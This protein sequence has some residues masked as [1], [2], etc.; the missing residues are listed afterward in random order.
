M[1]MTTR[2]IKTRSRPPGDIGGGRSRRTPPVI[3]GVLALCPFF[4]QPSEADSIRKFAGA[5]LG[6]S[7]YQFDQKIDQKLVFSTVNVTAG[8]S[9]ER[10]NFLFNYAQS[11]DSAEVSEEEFTGS[12][13]RIDLDL[14]VVR[15][16]N[17]QLSVFLGYKD[18]ETQLASYSRDEDDT[19][20]R[21][22]SFEQEGFFV[23]ASVN[24]ILED[25]GRL[26]LSVAYAD[27]DST[28]VFV[29]DGDGADPGEEPEFDDI[30]GT[31]NGQ[32][33]GYSYNLAWTLPL[34][35]NWL[36]RARL[37]L[38]RYKQDIVFEGT[39]FN[40]IDEGSTTIL[41]GLV[42]VF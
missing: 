19:M 21:D 1:G 42:Y 27:L 33:T 8:L 9:Y 32:T 29:S 12:A 10:Y 5:D 24:W 6:Y 36:Y 25:A 34:K 41:M 13:D 17:K 14:L 4:V 11:F 35:G 28:N 20:R 31:T 26:S 38:N 22:E 2:Y 39:N 30:T 37:K 16:I 15:Q 23:G 40:N 3:L 18:G 7:T